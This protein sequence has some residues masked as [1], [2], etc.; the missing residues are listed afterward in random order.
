MLLHK[1]RKMYYYTDMPSENRCMDDSILF[2]QNWSNLTLSPDFVVVVRFLK[3]TLKTLINASSIFDTFLI[4]FHHQ[5]QRINFPEYKSDQIKPRFFFNI[6]CKKSFFADGW[7]CRG[8]T[9]STLFWCP[10]TTDLGVIKVSFVA[11]LKLFR[12]YI[13]FHPCL[14]V[15]AIP[16]TESQVHILL[17]N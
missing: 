13:C 15:C 3:C 12:L 14:S 16:K 4:P 9:V 1:T 7:Y 11:A 17:P 2:L 8:T 10:K 5:G 6:S